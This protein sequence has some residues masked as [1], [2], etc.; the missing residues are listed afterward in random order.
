MGGFLTFGLIAPTFVRSTPIIE[1]VLKNFERL[2]TLQG[3][4]LWPS[5][6]PEL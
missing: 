2:T 3:V 4:S 1:D 5:A 6:V